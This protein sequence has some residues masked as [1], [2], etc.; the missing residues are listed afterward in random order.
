MEYLIMIDSIPQVEES[1]HVDDELNGHREDLTK[2]VD[3]VSTM[4]VPLSHTNVTQRFVR[5]CQ[6]MLTDINDENREVTAAD[7]CDF[8][9]RHNSLEIQY[10]SITE[11]LE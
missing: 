6:T 7:L 3:K 2:W 10:V 4:T 11:E 5:D 9:D 1:N 8:S